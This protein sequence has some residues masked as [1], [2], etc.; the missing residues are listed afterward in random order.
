MTAIHIAG[1]QSTAGIHSGI[2]AKW[3]GNFCLAAILQRNC[4]CAVGSGTLSQ[5]VRRSLLPAFLHTLELLRRDNLQVRKYLRDT[6][7]ASEYTG[8]SNID[9]DVLDGGVMERLTRAEVDEALLFERSGGFSATVAVL[10]GQIENAAHSRGFHGVDLNIKQLT[11]LLAYAPLLYQ[12][13]AIGRVTA[14][15]SA[16]HND[17]PQTGLGTNG[18]LDAFAGRLPVTDVV[19]QLV[20]M[21]IKPLLAFLGAP[22]LDAVVDEPF[23]NE[24]CFVIAAAKAVKHENKENVKGVQCS[25]TLNLLYGVALLGGHFEAG[26]TFL[27]KLSNNVPTHLCGE[28]MASLLLHGDVIL[29]DLLQRGNAIQAANSFS[30][31]HASLR[32][33]RPN[34]A[35]LQ[36]CSDGGHG[37]IRRKWC[38]GKMHMESIYLQRYHVFRSCHSLFLLLLQYPI[39]WGN[40]Q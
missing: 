22:D 39:H 31:G 5:I 37:I 40:V 29:F 35:V 36:N 16:L 15:K 12:L 25:F 3:T 21:V 20:H 27:G 23:H 38:K 33:E 2:A 30:Q 24:G 11:V 34:V 32:L 4:L 6:L 18:G 1:Q 9:E 7:T 8:V 10:V 26:D 17:L 28:L 19:Q 14:T 13:I